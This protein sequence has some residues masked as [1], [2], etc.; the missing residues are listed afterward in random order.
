MSH[1]QSQSV[2]KY[3]ADFPPETQS[4]LREIRGAIADAAPGTEE[5]ISYGIPTFDL[6]G[7]HLVHFGGYAKH[8]GFYPGATTVGE[9][10]SKELRPYKQGKGSV[11]FPL[12]RPMP[13][14][15]IRRMVAFRVAEEE[16]RKK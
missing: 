16:A 8:V 14:T 5:T 13:L 1:S 2:D 6:D 10:F 11:Q 15:L 12:D 7:R 4:R 9:A 3:I